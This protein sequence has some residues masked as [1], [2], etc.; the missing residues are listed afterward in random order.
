[1][2]KFLMYVVVLVGILF[3]GYTTYYFVRNNETISITLAENESV[4]I[5]KDETYEL[6]IKWTK[7]YS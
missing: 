5:N 7:P 1:M 6:P 4:Y 2:K 3:I